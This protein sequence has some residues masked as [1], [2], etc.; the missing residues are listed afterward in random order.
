MYGEYSDGTCAARCAVP[1][2]GCRYA[3]GMNEFDD[4][5]G[6]RRL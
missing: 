3:W 1:G 2:A 6:V 4:K 5:S